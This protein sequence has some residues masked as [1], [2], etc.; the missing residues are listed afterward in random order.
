MTKNWLFALQ[1][2][3]HPFIN[4]IGVFTRFKKCSGLSVSVFLQS[5]VASCTAKK[6]L[7][8]TVRNRKLV[9]GSI[10]CGDN[11]Y[12]FINEITGLNLKSKQLVLIDSE[13]SKI[14]DTCTCRKHCS[15]PGMETNRN[16]SYIKIQY[17]C[18][19]K[20]CCQQYDL[21]FTSMCNHSL[22]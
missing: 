7:T 3:S 5:M 4:L 14:R 8:V 21:I 19:G 17:E 9:N 22:R 12:I 16:D 10:S 6:E 20:D 2:S 11:S 13:L 18:I 15:V 1:N